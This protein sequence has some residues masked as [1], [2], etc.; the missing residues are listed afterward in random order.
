MYGKI[1]VGAAFLGPVLTIFAAIIVAIAIA[2]II[3]FL[4]LLVAD[5]IAAVYPSRKLK[6]E[7]GFY[8]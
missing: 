1:N 3:N 2:A 5:L 6:L 4:K 8:V 7:N